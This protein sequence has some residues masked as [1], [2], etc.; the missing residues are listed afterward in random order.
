MMPG[1]NTYHEKSVFSYIV[2]LE[3]TSIQIYIQIY[4]YIKTE[5]V[6]NTG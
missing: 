4:I 1:L 6:H 5:K 2:D 3:K